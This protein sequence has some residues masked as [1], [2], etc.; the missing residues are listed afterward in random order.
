MGPGA[1]PAPQ[2]AM[3]PFGTFR[4]VREMET[5][6]SDLLVRQGRREFH[7]R[8][9]PWGP[10]MEAL[11]TCVTDLILSWGLNIEV[12][13]GLKSRPVPKSDPKDWL[14]PNDFP[15][16]LTQLSRFLEFRLMVD[17]GG[18]PTDCVVYGPLRSPGFGENLC[19]ALLE[20]ARFEP[21]SD[22]NGDSV[23]SFWRSSALFVP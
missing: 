3:E 19:K 2:Y 12:Q 20:R 21:A 1:T 7:L 18:V 22:A 23:A 9:G 11:R 6:R 13:Q 8:T 15:Q 17:A 5:T 16:G 4:I 14:T 10:P